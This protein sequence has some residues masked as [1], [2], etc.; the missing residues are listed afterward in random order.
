V[1]AA[2]SRDPRHRRAEVEPRAYFVLDRAVPQ[3][4]PV[5]VPTNARRRSQATPL[6]K[7]PREAWSKHHQAT[8]EE[9]HATRPSLRWRHLVAAV[10]AAAISHGRIQDVYDHAIEVLHA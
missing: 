3:W 10:Q 8:F 1:P 4:L 2:A 9:F 7:G 5:W 6:G